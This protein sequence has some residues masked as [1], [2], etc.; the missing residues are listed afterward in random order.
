MKII[1]IEEFR[2]KVHDDIFEFITKGDIVSAE[3]PLKVPFGGKEHNA[4]VM[5]EFE[6]RQTIRRCLDI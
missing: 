3:D 1:T 6:I 5:K 2:K 4:R